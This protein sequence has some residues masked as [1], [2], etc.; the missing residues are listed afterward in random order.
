MRKRSNRK[1]I[2]T[3]RKTK[4]EGNYQDLHRHIW[5]EQIIRLGQIVSAGSLIGLIYK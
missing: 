1:I 3:N 2:Y 4:F 5:L